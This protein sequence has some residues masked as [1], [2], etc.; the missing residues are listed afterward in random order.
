VPLFPSP[1][2]RPLL[3]LPLCRCRPGHLGITLS[4]AAENSKSSHLRFLPHKIPNTRW[5]YN[6]EAVLIFLEMACASLIFMNDKSSSPIAF[7]CCSSCH[8]VAVLAEPTSSACRMQI[9]SEAPLPELA[10]YMSGF[11]A[12]VVLSFSCARSKD[13]STWQMDTERGCGW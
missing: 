7:I 12:S 3:V 10:E 11:H 4:A 5:S 6:L 2:R 1:A 8:V 13:R 9:T